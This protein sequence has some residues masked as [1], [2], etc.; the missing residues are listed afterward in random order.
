L[1]IT[2]D[3]AIINNEATI[4]FYEARAKSGRF[5]HCVKERRDFM[6]KGIKYLAILF[7][8]LAVVFG[9]FVCVK[10]FT[11]TPEEENI[12]GVWSAELLIDGDENLQILT[13]ES[14]MIFNSDHRG[15]L[16]I[17][18][19][20][21]NITDWNYYKHSETTCLYNVTLEDDAA[22]MVGIV[23]DETNSLYGALYLMIPDGQKVKAVIFAKDSDASSASRSAGTTS[24]SSS[25][26]STT[27]NVSTGKKNALRSA[28]SYL[29]TMAFSRSGLIEQLEFEGYT[30]EE[31]VY[32]VDN[33]GANWKEQAARCAKSY[34]STMAFSRSELIEQL[35]FE[36][37]TSEQAI[38]GVTQ[39]GY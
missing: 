29:D 10:K 22:T 8:C 32:A 39:N 4:L 25:K 21:Y 3:D 27:S 33:C 2:H 18:D 31:A 19:S 11:K 23:D 16:S 9:L 7:C 12:I 36:G 26:S 14:K 28:E 13:K 6:K 15:S 17:G 35:E 24:S 5:C 38:Y 37:F 30:N 34:L 1:N 20:T